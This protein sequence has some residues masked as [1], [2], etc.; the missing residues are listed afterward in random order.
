MQYLEQANR[1][2]S[3][4]VRN[5]GG[6]WQMTAT[7]GQPPAKW[8]VHGLAELATTV[9]TK[10]TVSTVQLL[11][12]IS[13]TVW[14]NYQC[15]VLHALRT[16]SI[17]VLLPYSICLHCIYVMPTQ[18]YALCVGGGLVSRF[19]SGRSTACKC[20]SDC[21]FFFFLAP[22]S[23]RPLFRQRCCFFLPFF[24]SMGT[25]CELFLSACRFRTCTF[26]TNCLYC[27]LFVVLLYFVSIL[28][29]G[30]LLLR[31]CYLC[32]R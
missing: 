14:P 22:V 20:V 6:G 13:S 32:V 1:A 16:R 29:S 24:C 19:I 30:P 9:K 26:L 28:H 10:P 15:V 17:T 27:Q 5:T 21:S 25:L 23:R 3:S 7:T 12:C 11:L 8:G 4:S 31:S 18:R 2:L